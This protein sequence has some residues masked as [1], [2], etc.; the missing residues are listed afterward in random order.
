MSQL[1]KLFKDKLHDRA[2]EFKDSYWEEAEQLIEQEEDRRRRGGLWWRF[3]LVLVLFSLTGYFIMNSDTKASVAGLE[4]E[5]N[6]SKHQQ[7]ITSGFENQV[8]K[9]NNVGAT[10][11][12]SAEKEINKNNE[13]HKLN[14]TTQTKETLQQIP[15]KFEGI[16][17]YEKNTPPDGTSSKGTL[18]RALKNA[19]ALDVK[20]FDIQ[21]LEISDSSFQKEPTKNKKMDMAQQT[22]A[23]PDLMAKKINDSALTAVIT[24]ELETLETKVSPIDIPESECLA[25][26]DLKKIKYK[27]KRF[28][29]GLGVEGLY[30][31]QGTYENS[32]YGMTIGTGIKYKLNQQLTLRSGLQVA[33]IKELDSVTSH[34][35]SESFDASRLSADFENQYNFGLRTVKTYYNPKILNQ[36]ELPLLIQLTHK[37]HALE[38]GV[39]FSMLIGVKGSS[40]TEKSLFPWEPEAFDLEEDILISQNSSIDWL[41]EDSFKKI[42]N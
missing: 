4:K 34:S 22:V 42:H 20:T 8:L 40:T 7:L 6:L 19:P 32:W 18:N 14:S 25:C 15:S 27:P 35:S 23:D 28:A 26:F 5:S 38:V 12:P 16:S 36:L 30:Y 9:T 39:Q 2:F 41:P 29:I 11:S 17:S 13:I 31:P 21:L 1:D 3:G 10:K 33:L 37:R 24:D